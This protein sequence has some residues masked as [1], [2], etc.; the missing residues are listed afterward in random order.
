M[1][2]LDTELKLLND[3]WRIIEWMSFVPEDEKSESK[4]FKKAFSQLQK[5]YPTK[6][7]KRKIALKQ[8]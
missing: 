1:K 3:I 8:K 4:A 5:A 7:A 6:T 2:R